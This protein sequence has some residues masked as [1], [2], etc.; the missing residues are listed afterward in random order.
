MKRYKKAP[1]SEK[2]TEAFL[3][4]LVA[5]PGIEPGTQG[6]SIQKTK[7]LQTQ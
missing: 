1:E 3:I 5:R 2:I 4:F 7:A 6:F